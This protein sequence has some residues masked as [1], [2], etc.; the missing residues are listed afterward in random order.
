MS[1]S[2]RFDTTTH[3]APVALLLVAVTS[4]DMQTRIDSYDWPKL[5]RSTA[6]LVLPTRDRKMLRRILVLLIVLLTLTT[7]AYADIRDI[8]VRANEFSGGTDGDP[9]GGDYSPVP[10]S[11]FNVI[12]PISITVIRGSSFITNVFYG[13]T[14][15]NIQT[16]F[17]HGRYS[18]DRKIAIIREAK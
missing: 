18:N 9:D 5:G 17:K 7:S 14:R 1:D 4:G 11:E 6:R 15:L 2:S 12:Y 10:K 13:N 3:R 8:H 16:C